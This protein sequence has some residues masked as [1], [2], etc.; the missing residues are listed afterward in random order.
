MNN[1][2]LALLVILPTDGGKSLVRDV[3]GIILGGVTLTIIPLLSLGADQT[4]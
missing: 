2:P 4:S 3:V 1:L